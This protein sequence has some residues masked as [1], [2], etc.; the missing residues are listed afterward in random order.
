MIEIV[1]S[2]SKTV[3]SDNFLTEFSKNLNS[4]F[5]PFGF[6]FIIKIWVFRNWIFVSHFAE[7]VL[8]RWTFRKRYQVITSFQNFP[9]VQIP[10]FLPLDLFDNQNFVCN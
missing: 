7:N 4:E 1:L 8:N 10:N 2:I 3:S 6:F 9:K 5:S